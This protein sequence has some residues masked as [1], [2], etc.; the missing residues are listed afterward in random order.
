MA[1]GI[2]VRTK[3]KKTLLL[4]GEYTAKITQNHYKDS[5]IIKKTSI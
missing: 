5:A 2:S 3:P 1:H 4:K